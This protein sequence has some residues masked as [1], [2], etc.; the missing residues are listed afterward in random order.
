MCELISMN[1]FGLKVIIKIDPNYCTFWEPYT[2][3]VK[4]LYS[5]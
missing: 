5:T 3:G 4:N 1:Y 2:K